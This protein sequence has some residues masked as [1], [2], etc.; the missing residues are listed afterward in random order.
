MWALRTLRR[1]CAQGPR[2]QWLVY[3]GWTDTVGGERNMNM[4]DVLVLVICAT[5]FALCWGLVRFCE[6]LEDNR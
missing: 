5:V 2:S 1:F 4:T 6:R 3:A